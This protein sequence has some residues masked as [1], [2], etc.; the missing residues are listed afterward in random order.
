MNSATVIESMNTLNPAQQQ[1]VTTT[2]GPLLVLAGPGSG[3]TR[4]LTQR[5]AHL[6]EKG[7]APWH[8][9]AV[10]FTNK[11]SREMRHRLAGLIGDDAAK[12]T[13]GTFHAICAQ[14][15]RR[16]IHHLGY[17]NSFLVYDSDDQ[18][19]LVKQAIAELNL[20]EK[21]YR[22]PAIHSVI[23]KAKN[24]G[25][26]PDTFRPQSYYE[27]IAARVFG[28]Y[29]EMLKANQAVDF[30]DLLLLT[31][32][33]LREV[34][35]VLE[36]YRQRWHYLHVDEF[37]D[38]NLVQYELVRL[39]GKEH[40]NVFVVGDIDQSIYAWRG[41]D[42]RN[43][44]RFEE[45]FPTRVVIAL[46]QNY[47]STQTI[48]DAASALIR[49]NRNRKDKGLWSK[50]GTGVPIVLFEAYDENEEAQYVTRE[51]RRL[52]NREGIRYRDVSVMYR[53]NAQSRA[54]EEAFVKST[55][56]YVLVGGTRFYERREVKDILAYLRL[57]HNPFDSISLDRIINVPTRSIGN[58]TI[59]QLFQW[60]EQLGVPV[61][62]A[63]QLLEG[64]VEGANEESS[65]FLPSVP[66]PFNARAKNALI[67]FRRMFDEWLG[68]LESTNL[69]GLIGEIVTRTEYRAY[70]ED[71]TKEGEERWENVV[72]LQ[73]VAAQFENLTAK[74]ALPEFLE[75]AALVSD[76]DS[77]P[78][79]ERDAV[80]LM[81]LHTAKGL[82]FPVVFLV[83]MNDG[84]LPHSRSQESPEQMEEER[85]LAYVGIT[86]AKQRLYLLYTFRRTLW[87][88]VDVS[89]PSPFLRELPKELIEVS[90]ERSL[91]PAGERRYNDA[92]RRPTTNTPITRPS[93]TVVS[94][95]SP[96][97][98]PPTTFKAGDKVRHAKFGEG[99]VL[100]STPSGGDEEVV[101]IFP[102]EKPKKLLASFARLEKV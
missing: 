18:R 11:A 76:A 92:P 93:R 32:K 70:L 94:S 26:A 72:E 24:D 4:V 74:A 23:S 84:V 87:G 29:Q 38:T 98:K 48:L 77:L 86:R 78:D 43:I 1:A 3:K 55:M 30:D 14:V 102:G 57:I 62:S 91:R 64:E 41:A 100:T 42:Y 97:A 46:E 19:K 69:P 85:R 35:S 36:N 53:T 10:T 51:I 83:G 22:A 6:I 34:P 50:L 81:T 52:M 75:G 82:E 39:L 68:M 88:S 9:L 65:L 95:P 5:I 13:M 80:T 90:G 54:L 58:T 16:N 96:A 49:R 73:N 20:S 40:Q 61:F 25:F 56:P 7:V 66:V 12:V 8:I 89:V 59:Q 101:V 21:T 67:A 33:L 79:D 99:I 2:E 27:E 17:D 37:Q 71:G 15:L 28:R 31:A 44:L 63:L 45:D 47:R 60:A